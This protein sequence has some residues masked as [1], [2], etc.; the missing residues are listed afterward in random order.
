M[1]ATVASA[2]G[3]TAARA[4]AAEIL[5]DLRRGEFLDQTFERRI[6]ALDARDRRW[7]RELVYGMLRHRAEIDAILSERVRGGLARLDPDVIDLLRLGVYQL[8]NMGSVPAYA[9]IAQTVELAKRRHGLGA[10][11]LVNAVLRRTDREREHLLAARPTDAV[12]ALALRY[13]HPRW[14][15]ARWI[16][17]WGEQD[18]ERLLALN[19]SEAPVI[20]RPFGIV[21]EQLEAMM[22]AAGVHVAEA[23]YARDSIAI[24]GGTTFTE[25]GAFKKGLFFVQDPAATLVTDYAAIPTGATVADLCAAPGGKALELSRSADAVVAADK[26][27]ARL[28]RLL[29]NQRRLE[30]ANILPFVADARAPAIRPVDAVL[31]DV[32]CTGTGTFRRH[33]DARWRI[34][35]SDIAVMSALQKSIL[36]AAA[37]VVRPDGILV[38]ST[39]SLEPEENDAQVDSFLA[40]NLNW[41]LE[42]PPEGSVA[43]ELLDGGRL[44]VLPHRHGTDGAFAARLRRTS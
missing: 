3:V 23:P 8:T 11:K 5:V 38:Y 21:R 13:S 4:V 18:T 27:F 25:L 28:Q 40:E 16:E 12:D 35:V 41:I 1:N 7:T 6:I 36:K 34:K 17:R 29:A 10:S 37:Q 22:E 30:S 31:I 33:P 24:S 14:L 20:I 44:R 43:P 19:N 32:P 39:C 26:S 15:I 9:A 42:P 2:S